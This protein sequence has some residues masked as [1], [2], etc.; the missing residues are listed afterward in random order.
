MA[1]ISK[2]DCAV[3]ICDTFKVPLSEERELIRFCV[4]ELPHEDN[5]SRL[6]GSQKILFFCKHK[7]NHWLKRLSHKS[8]DDRNALA[9]ASLNL[10]PMTL[11]WSERIKWY[12]EIKGRDTIDISALVPRTIFILIRYHKTPP[13]YNPCFWCKCN[14]LGACSHSLRFE[15][16][17]IPMKDRF[18]TAAL[19]HAAKIASC[20]YEGTSLLR[21]TWHSNCWCDEWRLHFLE[22]REHKQGV[23]EPNET[24]T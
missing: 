13:W 11:L 7:Q 10:S 14:S 19:P 18:Y 6:S 15:L 9:E 5:T 16:H 22:K 1:I 3:V 4:E 24:N 21:L 12:G 17:S 2:I 23:W 8:R 20:L